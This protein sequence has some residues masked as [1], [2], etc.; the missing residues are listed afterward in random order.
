M[1]DVEVY[2]EKFWPESRL[3]DEYSV[4]SG[5]HEAIKDI[6]REVWV[7]AQQSATPER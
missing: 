2:I 4:Y 1:K 6:I 7:A 3:N 5:W